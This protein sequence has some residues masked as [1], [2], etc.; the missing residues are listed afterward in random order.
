MGIRAGKRSRHPWSCATTAHAR[1]RPTEPAPRANPDQR[2][3]PSHRVAAIAGWR[4]K[5]A[6]RSTSPARRSNTR[7]PSCCAKR[8]AKAWAP[9]AMLGNN[10]SAR[11][12]RRWSSLPP[13]K[14]S[15][16]PSSLVASLS[17]GA[18]MSC[19][20]LRMSNKASL[21]SRETIRLSASSPKMRPAG[22]VTGA[23][24]GP[25]DR[26]SLN[27]AARERA[28]T[29]ATPSSMSSSCKKLP[30]GEKMTAAISREATSMFP[31][32]GAPSACASA[33]CSLGAT[34]NSSGRGAPPNSA[35]VLRL[36][37]IRF[38]KLRKPDAR[39]SMRW[40]AIRRLPL[41]K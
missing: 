12:W 16:P 4:R 23:A 27:R 38:V 25:K 28:S 19:V 14:K 24:S 29:A 10:P 21:S 6:A 8:L 22:M 17:P 5:P 32:S 11:G 37:F 34:S 18:R 41:Y 40:T 1:V 7:F 30:C 35:A 39:S 9:G 20:I 31:N 13:C 33:A 26:R 15:V 2:E 36:P 3:E